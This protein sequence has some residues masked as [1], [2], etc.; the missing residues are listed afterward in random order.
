MKSSHISSAG[1][2]PILPVDREIDLASLLDPGEVAELIGD[3]S[4]AEGSEI[5]DCR[6]RHVRY[7]PHESCLVLYDVDYRS[8]D[9]V[10]TK[11]L[12]A[13]HMSA[14]GTVLR[15]FPDDPKLPAIRNLTD[16]DAFTHDLS[17]RLTSAGESGRKFK[18]LGRHAR[19]IRYKPEN[20]L[21]VRCRIRWR[22]GDSD[23]TPS[24]RCLLRF[25]RR[26]RSQRASIPS[27][28]VTGG[29]VNAPSLATPPILF[30][31]PDLNCIGFEWVA[32]T[33]L[34]RLLKDAESRQAGLSLA[35]R[36]LAT[37]HEAPPTELPVGGWREQ[38]RLATT[39]QTRLG[40]YPTDMQ[41][42]VN[43]AIRRLTELGQGTSAGP[44]GFVHGDFHQGQLLLVQDRP[45]VLDLDGAYHGETVADVGSFVGQ[46]ELLVLRGRLGAAA[47]IGEQFLAEYEN[48]TERG[49]DRRRLDFWAGLTLLGLA[50]KEMR[51]LKPDWH[52]RTTAILAGCLTRLARSEP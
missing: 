42:Q 38:L 13:K 37:L 41:H 40:G 20:R 35:A 36:A 17:A 33:K 34:S 23:E 19:I 21:I 44:S 52:E 12:Y 39:W 32:G 5:L 10:N 14:T 43:E 3:H 51:R 28:S 15:E 49:L 8:L 6:I 9:Q 29:M 26:A 4:G 22:D 16:R 31:L 25:E 48:A 50:C 46:L 27:G 30:Q 1:R 47:T 7:R 2:P 24:T 18:G 45:C 11:T